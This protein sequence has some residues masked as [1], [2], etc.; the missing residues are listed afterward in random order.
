[1]DGNDIRTTGNLLLHLKEGNR[2]EKS[3]PSPKG[4]LKYILSVALKAYG[5][6]VGALQIFLLFPL[7]VASRKL[8][9]DKM[10]K[11]KLCILY[12]INQDLPL[13]SAENKVAHSIYFSDTVKNL[14]VKL[15]FG[16]F[17]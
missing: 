17:P 5:T 14:R 9:F 2:L 11:L 4:R 10:K 6:L 16:V 15:H 3:F 12:K 7:P 8:S 13:L 1:M